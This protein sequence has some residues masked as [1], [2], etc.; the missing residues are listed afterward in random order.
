MTLGLYENRQRR[1]RRFR[2]GLARW[3]IGLA[4]VAATGTFAYDLGSRQ[5]IHRVDELRAQ[6]ED[7]STRQKSLQQQNTELQA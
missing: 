7:L 2:W 1:R 6:F 5:S 4:A 3:A